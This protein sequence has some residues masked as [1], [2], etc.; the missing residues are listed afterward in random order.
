MLLQIAAILWALVGFF[1]GSVT[2]FLIGGVACI[3][4]D[5]I[6]LSIKQLN[7]VLFT[8]TYILCYLFFGEWEGFIFASIILNTMDIIIPRAQEMAGAF[9]EFD[10]AD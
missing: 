4:L 2:I 9:L 5:I 8:S 1:T 10:K 3:F 6:K 7:I